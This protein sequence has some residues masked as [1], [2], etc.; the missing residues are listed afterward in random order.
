MEV[1]ALSTYPHIHIPSIKRKRTRR[2][3]YGLYKSDPFHTIV[4]MSTPT[5]MSTFA[6]LVRPL[7]PLTPHPSLMRSI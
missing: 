7:Q 6:S 1:R 3:A 2:E 5:V 4:H